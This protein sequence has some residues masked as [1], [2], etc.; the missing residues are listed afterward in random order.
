[1]RVVVIHNVIAET[2]VFLGVSSILKM[3]PGEGKINS[4]IMQASSQDFAHS[5]PRATRIICAVT[6][7][8]LRFADHVTKR[9]GGLWEREWILH[10]VV[11]MCAFGT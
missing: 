1:M 11:R 8:S 10:G 4:D 6:S 2:E 7:C 5:R 9:N 3:T